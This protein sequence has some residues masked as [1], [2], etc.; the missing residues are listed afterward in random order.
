MMGILNRKGY[1]LVGNMEEA[2]I[3]LVN[4]CGFIESAKQESIETILEIARLSKQLI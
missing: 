2:D 3:A 1:K 4:T